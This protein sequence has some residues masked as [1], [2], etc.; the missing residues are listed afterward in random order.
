MGEAVP[1]KRS[2]WYHEAIVPGLK[3]SGRNPMFL[4]A[5]WMQPFDDFLA[6]IA[7]KQI[8][9]N[10]WL[11]AAQQRRNVHRCQTVPDVR[12]AGSSRETCRP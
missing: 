7:P 2:T 5:N 6:D 3:A 11:V 9:G 4:V 1:G 12:R 8:Y 10:T